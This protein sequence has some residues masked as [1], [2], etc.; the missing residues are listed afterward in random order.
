MSKEIVKAEK[1][2]KYKDEDYIKEFVVG[3]L[4]YALVLMITQ[5]IFRGIY[6]ENFFYAVICAL[7]LNILNFF[8][9]PFLIYLTLPLSI[10]TFGIAYPIVNVIILKLCDI[11]MG[12]AFNISGFILPF[13][14]AIFISGLKIFLDELITKKFRR[15]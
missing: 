3:L 9:K 1:V 6:V 13:F 5:S 2:Q 8:V 12:S 15:F 11:I 14:I 10:M 4:V 7:I